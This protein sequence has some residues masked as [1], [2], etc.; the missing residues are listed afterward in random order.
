MSA[1]D[2]LE[3]RLRH[4]LRAAAEALPPTHLDGSP[5]AVG[6][7]RHG[8]GDRSTG[9][10]LAL[11]GVAT[12]L[13]VAAAVTVATVRGDDGDPAD[14]H[15]AQATS[16]TGP[17]A[18]DL[19]PTVDP[20]PGSAVVVGAE[21]VSFGADGQPGERLP[22]TPLTEVQAVTSDRHGGWIACGSIPEDADPPED[23]EVIPPGTTVPDGGTPSAPTTTGVPTTTV[24]PGGTPPATSSSPPAT[25]TVAP[26]GT[27]P[28][29][30]TTVA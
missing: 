8:G 24:A 19:G 18:S 12:V 3:V 9:R 17:P 11:A 21:L 20:V 27:P 15:V 2:D 26:G 10:R 28:A 30:T 13:V 14:L 4:G 23:S 7:S 1:D 29:P 22:L 6:G 5:P 16:T 25:T